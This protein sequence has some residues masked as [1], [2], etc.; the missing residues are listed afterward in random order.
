MVKNTHRFNGKIPTAEEVLVLDTTQVLQMEHGFNASTFAARVTASTLSPI[1]CAISTAIGTLF[2][3]LHGGADQAALE[4]V[5][6][7]DGLNNA[8]DFIGNILKNKE[9]VMGMGHRVY[10]VVDPRA[11][12]LK[13]LARSLCLNTPFQALFETFEKVEDIM[14]LEMARKGRKI[15]ANIEFYKG[16]VFYSMGIPPGILYFAFCNE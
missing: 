11:R 7:I 9:K 15:R 3:R 4:M 1:E 16:P 12:I 2:G 10:R 6:K 13:P 8:E 14:E 5:L